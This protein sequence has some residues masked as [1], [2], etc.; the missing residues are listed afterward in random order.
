MPP[1]DA[2]CLDYFRLSARAAVGSRAV[3]VASL[4]TH[5]TMRLTGCAS[6]IVYDRRVTAAAVGW[7]LRMSAASSTCALLLMVQHLHLLAAV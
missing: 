2:S 1:R 4:T 3:Q 6:D 7:V 5:Y